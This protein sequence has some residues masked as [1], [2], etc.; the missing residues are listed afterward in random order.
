M[1]KA[2]KLLEHICRTERLHEMSN[3]TRRYTGL[4]CLLWVH[5]KPETQHRDPRVKAE[6]EPGKFS[7]VSIISGHFYHGT[8][9]LSAKEVRQVQ[10]YIKRHQHTL[11]AYY[12][13][14]IGTAELI[15]LLG[16]KDEVKEL[17][18]LKA[19]LTLNN[20]TDLAKLLL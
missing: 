8:G 10:A 12:Y 16:V 19:E 9:D 4:P 11:L 5:G 20:F 17:A 18:G 14:A 6:V 7:S 1:G 3:L 2:L 15:G 13:N